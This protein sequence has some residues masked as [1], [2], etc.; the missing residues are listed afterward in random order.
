[1][2][3]LKKRNFLEISKNSLAI[4]AVEAQK[5]VLFYIP[6]VRTIIPNYTIFKKKNSFNNLMTKMAFNWHNLCSMGK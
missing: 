5:L 3:L 6:I 1:M 4:M 2:C